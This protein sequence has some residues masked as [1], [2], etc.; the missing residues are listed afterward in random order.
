MAIALISK[1]VECC[2]VV[3]NHMFLL[4]DFQR[5]LLRKPRIEIQKVAAFKALEE[6]YAPETQKSTI[7]SLAL[8]S[9]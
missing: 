9:N 4:V 7:H 5:G 3:E 6:D 1:T 8:A 2:R